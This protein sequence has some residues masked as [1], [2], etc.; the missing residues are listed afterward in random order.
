MTRGLSNPELRSSKMSI[1]PCAGARASATGDGQGVADDA[2][3]CVGWCVCVRQVCLC[4]RVRV[5]V[6]VCVHACVC[7]CAQECVQVWECVCVC[8]CVSV[9]VCVCKC[10]QLP[11]CTMP[12]LMH[13]R[14]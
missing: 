6:C 1:M 14:L 9:S 4:V 10:L 7:A 5:R 13:A 3:E 11:T 2:W 12:V 8:V